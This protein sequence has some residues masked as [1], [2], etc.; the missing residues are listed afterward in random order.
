MC[1]LFSVV[2]KHVSLR[3]SSSYMTP[4]NIILPVGLVCSLN[5]ALFICLAVC[6][7]HLIHCLSLFP[8]LF[9][10]LAASV[11]LCLDVHHFYRSQH[12][13]SP[14][15]MP[16]DSCTVRGCHFLWYGKAILYFIS[17]FL[18]VHL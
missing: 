6:I 11:T 7:Y 9:L 4:F 2:S 14:I 1:N 10:A 18:F 3:L 12:S 8:S 5:S 16:T 13:R 17:P 15:N